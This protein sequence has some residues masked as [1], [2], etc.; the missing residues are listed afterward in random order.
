[1]RSL[2]SI[3]IS[4]TSTSLIW[5]S[6]RNDESRKATT[7]SPGPPNTMARALSQLM[8]AR[9]RSGFDG[10]P[11]RARLSVRYSERSVVII[12]REHERSPAPSGRSP[13]RSERSIEYGLGAAAVIA[14]LAAWVFYLHAGLVLSHYDAKAHLVVSRRVIDSLTPGW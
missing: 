4:T 5:G 8:S 9:K 12:A 14:A 13:A 2:C 1:M 11:A 7:N 6:E 3:T 10:R